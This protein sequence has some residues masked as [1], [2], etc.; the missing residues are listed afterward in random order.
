MMRVGFD[1]F[2]VFVGSLE[3]VRWREVVEGVSLV[4]GRSSLFW[5]WVYLSSFLVV[6]LVLRWFL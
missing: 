4:L 1:V 5:S 3:V 2:L 6:V